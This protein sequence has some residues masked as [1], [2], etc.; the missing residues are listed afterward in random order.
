M[1]QN[2]QV[3]D[4]VKV[5][6]CW[7]TLKDQIGTIVE[8][9]IAIGAATDGCLVDLD[10][11]RYN[12]LF[13]YINELELVTPVSVTFQLGD[14]VRFAQKI[15]E[16]NAD[17]EIGDVGIV[18]DNVNYGLGFDVDVKFNVDGET[19]SFQNNE[20][21]LEPITS[22]CGCNVT[23]EAV[24]EVCEPSVE[25]QLDALL[26]WIN[27]WSYVGESTIGSKYDNLVNSYDINSLYAEDKSVDT[28]LPG[29]YT[30]EM[31]FTETVPA[32]DIE[33]FCETFT[34]HYNCNHAAND[35]GDG[36]D[37][38]VNHTVSGQM[39]TVDILR[40]EF[41]NFLRAAGFVV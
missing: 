18:V 33:E 9:S 2:F 22:D 4:Q 24:C 37:K 20:L 27:E 15:N 26:A 14:Q 41:D 23:P 6:A 11:N 28:H 38:N 13:F 1:E 25:E 19:E 16:A 29:D 17:H 8:E 34:F 36:F 35:A 12:P 31:D 5:V 30:T 7:S 3:G 39:V 21:E 10:S 40:L 32:D